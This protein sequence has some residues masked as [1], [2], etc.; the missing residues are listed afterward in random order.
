VLAAA[1]PVLLALSGIGAVMGFLLSPIGL[2]VVGVAGLAAAWVSNF[3]DIQGKTA[4]AWAAIQPALMQAWAWVQVALPVAI[5]WL[6]Q[7]WTAAWPAMQAAWDA[8]WAVLSGAWTS[9]K[10]WLDV[11]L[12]AAL[13]AL[14]TAWVAAWPAMQTAWD[15]AWTTLST[16]FETA[17]TW[18]ETTLPGAL[19]TLQTAFGGVTSGIDALP[20]ALTNAKTQFDAVMVPIGEIGNQLSTLFAPALERV[21]AAFGSLPEKLGPLLPQLQELAGAFG[22]LLQAVQPLV[23]V[24]GAALAVAALFGVNVFA[25]AINAL[26]GIV[27]PIIDQVTATFKL[28]STVLTE[29]VN[30]VEGII[31]GDWTAVWQSAQNIFKAFVE[32]FRGNLIRFRT[33][34]NTIFTAIYDA[35][36]NTLDDLGIDIKPLLDTIKS[37]WDGVWN[38]LKDTVQPVIDIVGLVWDKIQEFS[39]WLGGLTL[40]NPFAPL[41]DAIGTIA[42]YTGLGGKQKKADGTSYFGGGYTRINER[43][44]EGIVLPAGSRILTN[45]QTNNLPM[46]GG[47]PVI[48]INMSGVQIRN[49]R[50]LRSIGWQLGQILAEQMG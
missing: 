21:Q 33:L 36:V 7:Q 42:E 48:N 17:R 34:T 28:I 43:G 11:T 9:A 4:E 32:F 1:G 24:V 37:T 6:Q 5:S 27:G 18:L 20:T 15:T 44:D 35:V 49:D 8:V 40:P 12:P 23:M 3:G 31:D 38:T 50:D 19:T 30:L 13:T 47:A 22:G 45:G 10:A 26:P 46:A 2:L 25:A 39:N 14:Q 41:S 16:G 29:V